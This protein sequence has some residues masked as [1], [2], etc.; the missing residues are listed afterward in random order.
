LRQGKRE[1]K[2]GQGVNQGK[3]KN[4][5][6]G[7]AGP[8]KTGRSGTESKIPERRGKKKG[9]GGERKKIAKSDEVRVGDKGRRRDEWEHCWCENTRGH[10]KKGRRTKSKK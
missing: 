5:G 10:K 9:V 6:A 4:K 7:Q 2:T 8:A 1:P 3:G